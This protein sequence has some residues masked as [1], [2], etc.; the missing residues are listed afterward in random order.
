MELSAEALELFT[1]AAFQLII[2]KMAFS[3]D[4]K[5]RL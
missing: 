2:C 3:E 5:S 1:H 4:A